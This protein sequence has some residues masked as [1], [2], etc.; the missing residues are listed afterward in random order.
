MGEDLKKAVKYIAVGALA[1]YGA[2]GAAAG[3][4]AWL[5]GGATA[6]GAYAAE[7]KLEGMMEG[8][9]GSPQ[10]RFG[11]RY[12]ES[13]EDVTKP[14]IFGKCKIWPNRVWEHVTADGQ[15]L[16]G[17]Y[18]IGE[19][20]IHSVSDVQVDGKDIT[21][22][23]G[24]SYTA[25]MGTGAQTLDS[26][27]FAETTINACEA[28]T[29]WN[30]TSLTVS[31]LCKQGS[32]SLKDS[33]ASP[34]A[35]TEYFFYYDSPP[36]LSAKDTWNFWYR[37]G[38]DDTAF[39]TPRAYAEDSGGNI[40]Y[41]DLVWTADT[42]TK[43]EHDLTSPD[44]N[45]GTDADLSDLVAIGISLTAADTT[46]WN[47]YLDYLTSSGDPESVTGSMRYTAYLAV[48]LEMSDQVSGDPTITCIVE[49][50]ECKYWNGAA[51]VV[52]TG[53]THS[54]NIWN[55]ATELALR[56][57]EI[58]GL[59]LAEAQIDGTTF[60]AEADH[61]D[62]SVNGAARWAYNNAHDQKKPAVDWL[63][64]MLSVCHGVIKPGAD[65]VLYAASERSA[66]SQQTFTFSDTQPESNNVVDESFGVHINSINEEWNSVKIG[67]VDTNQGYTI[68]YATAMDSAD[69]SANGLREIVLDK[70][71]CPTYD[72]ASR[73][74]WFT[75][76]EL[77]SARRLVTFAS[78]IKGT[79]REVFDRIALTHYVPGWSGKDLRIVDIGRADEH[80][81]FLC[82]EYD[83]NLYGDT[84]A[85]AE[86]TSYA[87][88]LPD[89]WAIPQE[90][91][92]VSATEG[93]RIQG[94]GTYVPTIVLD[95]DEPT[96][97]GGLLS[98][99]I[100]ISEGDAL[101]YEMVDSNV[102]DTAYT[103]NAHADQIYYY[104]IQPVSMTPIA[105]AF[106]DCTEYN[107]TTSGKD[108]ACSDV[109]FDAGL[110]SFERELRVFWDAIADKDLAFYE[111]RD[112]GANWGT[113]DSHL[114]YQGKATNYI[115]TDPA[116]G[117]TSYT[118]YIKAR[119]WSG[120]Y[121]TNSDSIVL[122]NAVPANV[123]A[124]TTNP[125]YRAVMFS[126]P[127]NTE[128]DLAGYTYRTKV[129]AG[130]S[131]SS[132][133]DVKTNNLTR[134]L[135]DAEVVA[136]GPTAAIYIEVKAKDI[137]NQESAAATAANDNGQDTT[138]I[139]VENI[140]AKDGD[141]LN[142]MDDGGTLGVDIIDGGQVGIGIAANGSYALTIGDHVSIPLDK[143][144]YMGG[145]AVM[146]LDD[147]ANDIFFGTGSGGEYNFYGNGM[148]GWGV[149][150]SGSFYSYGSVG[151]GTT[152]PDNL[153]H[154]YDDDAAC[155]IHIEA[156][157]AFDAFIEID[158]GSEDSIISLQESG[159]PEF[160][161]L[162]D[163]SE[164]E[165]QIRAG[166][167]AGTKIFIADT[168]GN[169][170]LFGAWDNSTYSDNTAYQAPSDGLVIARNT[171]TYAA[172]LEGYTDGSNPP[173]TMR[174][175]THTGAAGQFTITFPVKKDDY[176]KTVG[177][178]VI[179]FIPFGA[180]Q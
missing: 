78:G 100:W 128:K 38:R 147:P 118:F 116:V 44:S 173:T 89:P 157:N 84:S 62:V 46:A 81:V 130:G 152:G 117:T 102:R 175:D 97:Y 180:D 26:R 58:G 105:R 155:G 63:N 55:Q 60:K 161:I 146:R 31:N 15:T 17:L 33:I 177:A 153:L 151:I 41:W 27:V 179:N 87:S 148:S 71:G 50:I 109:S 108:T 154:V 136:S 169:V 72:Q 126:W 107:I 88:T 99:S 110:S 93:S 121:S 85:G 125:L 9:G 37:N 69:I 4:K 53:W 127:R 134:E 7:K 160:T 167:S 164:S 43:F 90:V 74:A 150:K 52:D 73:D 166:S 170:E 172:P 86:P 139:S 18:E 57:E 156:D 11:Q 40:S 132:W 123:G 92:N 65:G 141:G 133:A 32:H 1:F 30:G 48:T 64:A 122:T 115:K 138:S 140:F 47:H 142:L 66:S 21:G 129:T 12:N 19:G 119:D 54:Q 111:V 135:T 75:L 101:S 103:H 39:T 10:R 162:H 145:I 124:L 68:Q 34:V 8:A 91:T 171:D 24:C 120:N 61:C 79:A 159:T 35:T 96:N 163:Q 67:Y 36:D 25:Y 144:I 178:D 149:I 76:Y 95:W 131:F 14:L 113:I 137:Y 104:R 6:Y 165:F 42:W 80:M 45:N 49:G 70:P 51:F 5:L 98:Y 29:N 59:G 77:M 23:T 13:R 106:S 83:A 3:A 114:I 28:T 94:D 20:E 174:A 22:L 16:Y 56:D 2:G 82:K 158:S 176:W 143:N 112:E 168:S